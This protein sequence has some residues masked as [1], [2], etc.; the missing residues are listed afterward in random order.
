MAEAPL[1][2]KHFFNVAR[3]IKLII[4]NSIV[5][6]ETPAPDGMFDAMHRI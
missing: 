6:Q 2:E 5:L 1:H 4:K 3:L